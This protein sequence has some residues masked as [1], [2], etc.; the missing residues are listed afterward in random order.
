MRRRLGSLE[1]RSVLGM[2]A[3][4]ALAVGGMSLALWGWMTALNTQS[5]AVVALGGVA[6]GG[7]VYA[8]LL[9]ALR[10]PEVYRVLR[11]VRSR[12]GRAG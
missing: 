4:A 10:V 2:L 11:F 1:G 5:P 3:K 6:L 7:L 9:A 8:G 12:L